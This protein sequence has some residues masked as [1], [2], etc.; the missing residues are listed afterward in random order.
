[1]TACIPTYKELWLRVFGHG[2]QSGRSSYF[3]SGEKKDSYRLEDRSGRGNS[4]LEYGGSRGLGGKTETS[5]YYGE[6]DDR[7]D[8][9]ILRE[10]S[11]AGREGIKM[12]SDV[13]VSVD[14]QARDK[15]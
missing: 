7:S 5:I 8:R 1:M 2:T 14:G 13:I 10:G 11:S 15:F 6:T 9:G 12:T 3:R 4:R